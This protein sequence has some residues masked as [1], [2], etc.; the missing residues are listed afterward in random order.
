[1]G[2]DMSIIKFEHLPKVNV[3]YALIMCINCV[4]QSLVSLHQFQMCVPI[5]LIFYVN[6]KY[7]C[8]KLF[9][10]KLMCIKSIYN[11]MAIEFCAKFV[12]IKFVYNSLFR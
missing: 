5:T 10:I 8:T 12:C 11:S 2:V 7:V 3:H 4:H 6:L 1:M 9:Y